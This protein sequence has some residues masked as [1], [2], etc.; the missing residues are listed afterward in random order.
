MSPQYQGPMGCLPGRRRAGPWAPPPCVG[1]LNFFGLLLMFRLSLCNCHLVQVST[2]GKCSVSLSP[3]NFG[4]FPFG[5]WLFRVPTWRG[6]I[7]T[8]TLFDDM[9]QGDWRGGDLCFFAMVLFLACD[10]GA[11]PPTTTRQ[12]DGPFAAAQAAQLQDATRQ[13][14]VVPRPWVFLFPPFA[15]SFPHFS[16]LA[17]VSPWAF[18]WVFPPCFLVLGLGMGVLLLLLDSCIVFLHLGQLGIRPQTPAPRPLSWCVCVCVC[19]CGQSPAG[20]CRVDTPRQRRGAALGSVCFL[21]V[22]CLQHHNLG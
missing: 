7:V 20:S 9:K 1:L 8:T 12:R 4:P 6:C 17:G 13:Q 3:S 16:P 10:L 18:P 14:G 22:F 19:V 15:S 5:V 21:F 11:K 2:L